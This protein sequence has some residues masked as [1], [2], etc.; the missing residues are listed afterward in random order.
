MATY[1]IPPPA[2][3]KCNRD[4]ITNWKI[5]RD[6]Y[7]DYAMAAQLSDKGEGVQVATLKTIIAPLGIRLNI[8]PFLNSN[9]Q[10]LVD[11]VLSTQ[12]IAHLRI[13]V[14]RAI[15]RAKQ[16]CILQHTIPAS[17]WDSIS[18]LTCLLYANKL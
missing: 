4:V 12:K 17:M 14:E 7:E 3:M 1:Q 2:P 5:F 15:G 18:E 6:A 8:P 10:M 16:F 11:D 9:M 13:H